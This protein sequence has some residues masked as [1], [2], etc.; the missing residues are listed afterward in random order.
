MATE[1]VKSRLDNQNLLITEDIY[2]CV[3]QVEFEEPTDPCFVFEV[4]YAI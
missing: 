4:L 2:N 3:I 1:I